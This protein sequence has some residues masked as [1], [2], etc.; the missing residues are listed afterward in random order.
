MQQAHQKGCYLWSNGFAS[1]LLVFLVTSVA[2]GP[3]APAHLCWCCSCHLWLHLC[4]LNFVRYSLNYCKKAFLWKCG[5][6]LKVSAVQKYSRT[7]PSQGGKEKCLK[8]RASECLPANPG[9]LSHDAALATCSAVK[10]GSYFWIATRENSSSLWRS[11]GIF[12]LYL[13]FWVV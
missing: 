4:V 11:C 13:E 5:L 8:W 2:Q 1:W 10:C 7:T 6:I 3:A 9:H 12:R